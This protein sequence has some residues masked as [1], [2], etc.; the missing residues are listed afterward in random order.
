MQNDIA[1]NAL[2]LDDFNGRRGLG[3]DDC[4]WHTKPRSVIAQALAVIASRG[5][6]NAA[7]SLFLRH[8]QESIESAAFLI[9]CGKL[10]ILKF[11]PNLR[12]SNFRQG[13]RV[14]HRRSHDRCPNP[15]RGCAHIIQRQAICLAFA[16]GATLYAPARPSAIA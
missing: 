2:C 11:E 4:H 6:N 1:A 15:L 13:L 3:H 9:G 10:Q 16:H 12:A 8:Q 14:H 7:F 5:R